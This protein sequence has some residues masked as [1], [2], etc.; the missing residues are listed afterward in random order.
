MS[1]AFG[2][3]N[4]TGLPKRNKG[5]QYGHVQVHH[6]SKSVISENTK[7]SSLLFPI[8]D[9]AFFLRATSP[10]I[11]RAAQAGARW[12]LQI[13]RKRLWMKPQSAPA[14]PMLAKKPART[15]LASALRDWLLLANDHWGWLEL[16]DVPFWRTHGP[17][18]PGVGKG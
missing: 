15:S 18:A 16:D 8:R 14:N 10:K 17:Y 11:G 1:A 6:M 2:S 4:R 3:I 13:M 7:I 5:A 9:R 12:A